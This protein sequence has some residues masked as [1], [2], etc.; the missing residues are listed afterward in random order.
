MRSLSSSSTLVVSSFASQ[1]EERRG[2]RRG[3]GGE[4]EEGER[5]ETAEWE[6]EEGKR[7]QRRKEGGER[8]DKEVYINDYK[9]H[10]HNSHLPL[11]GEFYEQS[12][13]RTVHNLTFPERVVIDEVRVFF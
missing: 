11:Q 13:S 5:G 4:E 7:G 12:I 10:I 2:G 6:D 9:F 3:K 1:P 8:E